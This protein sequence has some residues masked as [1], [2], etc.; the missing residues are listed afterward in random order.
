MKKIFLLLIVVLLAGC[1]PKDKRDNREASSAIQNNNQ[2]FSGLIEQNGQAMSLDP[3]AQEQCF[4]EVYTEIAVKKL[5][6][7]LY[8]DGLPVS[9]M[10][11]F[12]GI[13]KESLAMKNKEFR[14]LFKINDQSQQEREKVIFQRILTFAGEFYDL[15]GFKKRYFELTDETFDEIQSH[16]DI[17]VLYIENV[18]SSVED[19]QKFQPYD[20]RYWRAKT[21]DDEE[22]LNNEIRKIK[23]ELTKEAIEGEN[24][25]SW[26]TISA[27]NLSTADDFLEDR[28]ELEDKNLKNFQLF[29]H[30]LY[31]YYAYNYKD[32]RS[33]EK[34]YIAEIS[35][36][37]KKNWLY[38]AFGIF[39]EDDVD[40]LRS[41]ISTLLAKPENWESDN[42]HRA[43]AFEKTLFLSIYTRIKPLN[44]EKQSFIRSV[45][46]V[47]KPCL[48]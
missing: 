15:L 40:L 28:Y 36:H 47:M 26:N 35:R 10:G 2:A 5:L 38:L 29:W 12:L 13:D 1:D 18:G 32:K 48:Q 43:S 24:I 45:L 19:I 23:A 9:G 21:Y 4:G 44:M 20:K 42:Y 37:F 39:P 34:E 46:T 31:G 25:P 22:K 3:L 8:R 11:L 14:Y 17:P 16:T 30:S 27:K 33:I 7:G 6:D 41:D